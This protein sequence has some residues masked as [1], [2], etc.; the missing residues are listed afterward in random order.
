MNY[1]I[2]ESTRARHLRISVSS[3]GSVTLTKPAKTPLHKAESFLEDRATWI[4]EVQQKL[5]ERRKREEKRYGAPVLLPRLHRNTAAYKEAQKEARQRVEKI[6]QASALKGPYA[7]AR[8][9]IRNQKTRWGSC[10]RQGTLSFNYRLIYLSPEELQ[11]LVVH[12][13]AHTKHHN[14]GAEFWKEVGKH[15]PQYKELRKALKRY[16]W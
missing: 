8:I 1:R 14:H 9:T 7:Y 10:S 13:L 2:K 3:D 5:I 11:Y 15:V 6:V 16:R 12:E 4:H